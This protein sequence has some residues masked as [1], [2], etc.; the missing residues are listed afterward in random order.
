M[1][2]S[3]LPFGPHEPTSCRIEA[4]GSGLGRRSDVFL[5]WRGSLEKILPLLL[6]FHLKLKE[7]NILI[8]I[9]SLCK[10]EFFF[11]LFPTDE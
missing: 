2:N 10:N 3:N 7:K 4:V 1:K 9:K 8:L 6:I 5:G 11:L